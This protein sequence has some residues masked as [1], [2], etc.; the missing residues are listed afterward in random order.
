M[1]SI[2]VMLFEFFHQYYEVSE[3]IRQ[4]IAS[5]VVACDLVQIGAS[6]AKVGNEFSQLRNFSDDLLFYCNSSPF[7]KLTGMQKAPSH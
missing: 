2:T 5:I 3:T 6:L 1:H 4:K 7:Q